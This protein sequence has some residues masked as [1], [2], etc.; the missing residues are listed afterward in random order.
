MILPLFKPF[1][2]EWVLFIFIVLSILILIGLGEFFRSTFNW[3]YEMTRKFIHIFIGLIV[4]LSPF[5][6][7]SN[8]QLI[9]LSIL[10]IGVNWIT[11]KL[12]KF[13]SMNGKDQKSYGTLFFPLSFLFLVIL[14]WDKPI[15]LIISMLVMTLSD[16]LAS[17]I[18][19]RAKNPRS[20]IIWGDSK[21]WEGNAAMFVS[22]LAIIYMGTDFFAWYFGA[23]FFIP[24]PILLGLAI[25]TA[26]MATISE[27][28]SIRGSDNFSVPLVTFLAYELYLVNFTH[29]TLIQFLIWT[30]SSGLF[31]YF[32]WRKKVLS[33]NG[34]FGAFI[35]GILVFGSGGIQ[36]ILPLIIFFISSSI[37]SK[38][39][40]ATHS[41]FQQIS[42]RNFYQVLAN[43]GLATLIA[44]IHFFA[45]ETNYYYLFLGSIAAAIA[46]TWA[47]EIGAF[48]PVKPRHIL[49]F[50]S[51]EKGCS[52]GITPLGSF[53]AMIG[54]MLIAS[55]GFFLFSLP[56]KYFWIISVSGFL[57]NVIDSILGGSIQSLFNCSVCGLNTEK[58]THC[59]RPTVHIKGIHWIDNDMVNFMNTIAGFLLVLILGYYFA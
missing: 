44:L 12:N 13:Q 55:I 39:N 18:G 29:G 45:P 51:V 43:G 57:G 49:N 15:T 48:S 28:V 21:T 47:T 52:G 46:D 3:S 34:V 59:N 35:M 9:T 5:Y 2:N 20:Y 7:K 26:G 38:F 14:W 40:N 4:S 30:V 50:N 11:L 37:L 19:R 53:G 32:S 36:W 31:L 27:A 22:A 54:S 1:E 17:L 16:S 56:G 25:F 6:F 8:I 23:A 24:L 41:E 58:R 33:S 42:G 10:F